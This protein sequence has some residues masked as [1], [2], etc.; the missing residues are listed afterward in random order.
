MIELNFKMGAFYC[1]KQ[2]YFIDVIITNRAQR[3]TAAARPCAGAAGA[4]A[5]TSPATRL[6]AFIR[7]R[8]GAGATPVTDSP[9]TRQT[10]FR[11]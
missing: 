1:E 3:R 10:A 8:A 9:A 11:A 7:P 2:C 6:A 4:A 5:T